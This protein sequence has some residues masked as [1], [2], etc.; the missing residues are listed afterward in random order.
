MKN[1]DIIDDKLQQCY[2]TKNKI[3]IAANALVN[4][5]DASGEIIETIPSCYEIDG[6]SG[7][8][9]YYE[10][11]DAS[12]RAILDDIYEYIIP[13]LDQKIENLRIDFQNAAIEEYNEE[14]RQAS[15]NVGEWK[16]Q[17]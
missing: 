16:C 11:I 4:G 3:I 9:S 2:E 13:A 17:N 15:G 5:I 12:E 14:M 10:D 7:G 1:T 8:L 6:I